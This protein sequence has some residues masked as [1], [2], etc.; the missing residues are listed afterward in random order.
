MSARP[1]RPAIICRPTADAVELRAAQAIRQQVFVDEMGLFAESDQDAAD[2]RAIHLVALCQ[3]TIIGTVRVFQDSA[4]TWW[5]GRLA[6]LPGHRGRAGRLLIR[7]AVAVVQ[8]AGGTCF[9]ARV[10]VE[11]VALFR[12]LHWRTEGEPF[13]HCGRLH[14]LVEASL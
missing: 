12:A 13:E 7:K 11:N 9:R 5:G 1:V 2:T 14:Q 3:G 10:L 6:V 4:G 8:A